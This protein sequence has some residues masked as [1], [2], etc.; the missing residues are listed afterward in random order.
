[1]YSPKYRKLNRNSVHITHRDYDLN[2]CLLSL[3]HTEQRRRAMGDIV[4]F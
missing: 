1:M 3:G 2:Q 4:D